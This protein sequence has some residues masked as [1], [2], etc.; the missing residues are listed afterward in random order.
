[1]ARGVR[2]RCTELMRRVA[3]LALGTYTYERLAEMG[4]AGGF[5]IPG[6]DFPPGPELLPGDQFTGGFTSEEV[7]SGW[8]EYLVDT[9]KGSCATD[10]RGSVVWIG[11]IGSSRPGLR[12][13]KG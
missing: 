10:P 13:P 4:C 3:S 11:P 9:A 8:S 5:P 6:V 12:E 1:V 2:A 7:D